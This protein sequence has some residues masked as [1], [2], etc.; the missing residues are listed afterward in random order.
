M[1]AYLHIWIGNAI[2]FKGFS[3]Y[4][5]A[6]IK[7]FGR[8]SWSRS[9]WYLIDSTYIKNIAIAP[10][11]IFL[12]LRRVRSTCLVTP[13]LI[14]LINSHLWRKNTVITKR[15]IEFTYKFKDHPKHKN[16]WIIEKNLSKPTLPGARGWLS[17]DWMISWH[18]RV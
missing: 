17:V 12:L 8:P 7:T 15:H 3:L 11:Y 13:T 6:K 18:L 10:Y 1:H 9:D 16:N 5:V 14:L 4:Q 2:I